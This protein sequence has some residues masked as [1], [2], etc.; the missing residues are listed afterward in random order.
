[1]K[2][3]MASAWWVFLSSSSNQE[4]A[5]RQQLKDVCLS[6][7]LNFCLSKASFRW[8]WSRMM[9]DGDFISCSP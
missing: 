7:L 5:P 6:G 9:T 1:M 2:A 8:Q 4:G 3:H